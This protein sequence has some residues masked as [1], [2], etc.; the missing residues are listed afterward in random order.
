MEENE[1]EEE[2][3]ELEYDDEENEEEQE[4]FSDFSSSPSKRNLSSR[5]NE[6]DEIQQEE[7]SPFDPQRKKRRFTHLKEKNLPS[8]SIAL[9]IKRKHK[10]NIRKAKKVVENASILFEALNQAFLQNS[11]ITSALIIFGTTI[12]NPKE[13]YILQ[14]PKY[15]LDKPNS[16]SI[17][18][19]KIED[20]S[21]KLIRT[22]MT[23]QMQTKILPISKMFVLLQA[24]SSFEEE[25][26][27]SKHNFILKTSKVQPICLTFQFNQQTST[28]I[29]FNSLNDQM[30]WFQANKS[31]KGYKLLM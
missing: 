3:N 12:L 6:I 31:I 16:A 28:Q 2:M 23:H 20:C 30:L 5:I 22:L 18:D 7:I 14:F 29:E 4:F 8:K 26:F 9:A 27:V 15:S 13:S 21:K 25:N 19:P 10:S 11:G 17:I 24:T 1:I